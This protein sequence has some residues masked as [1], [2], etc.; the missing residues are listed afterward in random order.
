MNEQEL[1]LNFTFSIPEINL[2][3]QGI[4]ELPGRICNPLSEKIRNQADPQVK[5]FQETMQNQQVE[6]ATVV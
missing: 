2:I 4:Q 1:N 3:L 5:Q 6:D